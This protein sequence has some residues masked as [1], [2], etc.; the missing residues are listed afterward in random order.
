MVKNL[1]AM[2]ET[3]VG[4]ISLEKRMSSC[5]SILAWRIPRTED[6]GGLQFYG[7]QRVGQDLVTK[8]NKD[9]RKGAQDDH[10][11]Q[12]APDDGK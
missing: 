5:S 11:G 12:G 6:T 9:N 1:P 10:G 4:K 2:Q 3:W 7:L 8:H